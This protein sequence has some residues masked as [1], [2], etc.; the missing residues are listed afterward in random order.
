MKE[1]IEEILEEEKKARER[2]D[3]AKEKARQMRLETEEKARQFRAEAR[4]KTLKEVKAFIAKTEREAQKQKEEEL[5]QAY[6]KIQLLWGGKKE[7][8]K[9]TV[10]V[11]FQM[12]LGEEIKQL[13]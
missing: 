1:I 9:Q 2:I 8:F 13:R 4:E 11:L 10:R 12:V 7:K 5:Q 3:S 6:A